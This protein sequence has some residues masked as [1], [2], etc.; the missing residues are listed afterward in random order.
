MKVTFLEQDIFN[1]STLE[2]EAGRSLTWRP[3]WCISSRTAWA[4]Q[5]NP[6]K[7]NE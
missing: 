2:A 1:P 4:T 5:Q 6:V 3:A 7:M